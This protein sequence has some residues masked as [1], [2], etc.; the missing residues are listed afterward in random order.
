[1]RWTIAACVSGLLAS[2][3]AAEPALQSGNAMGETIGGSFNVR[4]ITGS[5]KGKVYCQVCRYGRSPAAVVFARKLDDRLA[6]LLKAVDAELTRRADDGLQ[7]FLCAVGELYADDLQT[8]A[9]PLK[10][11]EMP[12]TL[13]VEA[14]GPPS[15]KLNAKATVTVVVY[16][17][18]RKVTANFALAD[19]AELTDKRIAEIVGSLKSALAK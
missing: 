7:G 13:A 1:M 17:S 19:T 18:D 8:F 12:I 3:P 15:W 10:K 6:A 9:E 4:G 2:A 14:D 16:N 5:Q 11:L